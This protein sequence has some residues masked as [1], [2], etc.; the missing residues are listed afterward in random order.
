MQTRIWCGNGKDRDILKDLGILVD[1]ISMDL[2]EKGRTAWSRL[3]WL[4]I[5]TVDCCR[6]HGNMI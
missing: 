6:E 1:G 2:T 3:F 5:G 4:R